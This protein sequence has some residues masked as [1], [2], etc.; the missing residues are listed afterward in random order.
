MR[1]RF[2]RLFC[3]RW[4]A[5]R[6]RP[7]EAEREVR[8]SMFPVLVHTCV[9]LAGNLSTAAGGRAVSSLFRP[10][11]QPILSL[12]QS[13]QEAA[14]PFLFPFS[15]FPTHN[16]YHPPFSSSLSSLYLYHHHIVGLARQRLFSQR[17]ST[18]SK[19][20]QSFF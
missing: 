7:K 14:S 13:M 3:L 12:V 1:G 19:P 5:R 4:K 8:G 6:S 18:A 11:Q 17:C 9:N 10:R 15:L 20:I 2:T 16:H